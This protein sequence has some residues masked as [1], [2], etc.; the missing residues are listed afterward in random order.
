M[1]EVI[2]INDDTWRIE[3]DGV[4]FF[5]LCGR[6]QAALVDTG[7][8]APND[9]EIAEELT[10]LP[11]I[12]INT[13]ADPDHISGNAAF[14]GFYMNPEE[15]GNYRD[16]GGTNS[17]LPIHENDVIDLGERELQIVDIPGHTPGSIAI[18]D[19]KYRV[20]LSGDSVQNGHIFMFGKTRD[21]DRYIESLK[22]LKEYEGEFDEVYP[23]HG[24]IPEKPELID[25]LIEGANSI[26]AGVATG[27]DVEIF[28]C[29]ALFYKF[30]YAA[31]LC[32]AKA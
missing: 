8:N 22:H 31:F 6:D 15:E 5:L 24:S 14:E 26:R 17:F 29:K 3:D 27:K 13:H 30:D 12:L 2:K 28:G 4:R 20:L 1:A 19:K 23:C 32:E 7:L 10:D 18:I 9:R 25:K 11:L 16:N 21:I